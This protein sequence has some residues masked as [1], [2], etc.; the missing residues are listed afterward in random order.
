MA[1]EVAV[2]EDEEGMEEAACIGAGVSRIC[3]GTGSAQFY[4]SKQ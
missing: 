3:G 1:P 2:D 4:L